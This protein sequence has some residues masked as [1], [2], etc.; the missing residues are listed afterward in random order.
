MTDVAGRYPLSSADGQAIPLDIIRP[1]GLIMVEFTE[2]AGSTGV[3]LSESTDCFMLKSD[4][5]CLIRF[6]TSGATVASIPVAGTEALD[7]LFVPANYLAMISPPIGKRF[8][9]IIGLTTSGTCIIQYLQS[10][11]GLRSKSQNNRR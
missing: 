7:Y 4:R 6:S 9:S 10:W 5:E 2:F 8:A 1:E 3:K 11:S